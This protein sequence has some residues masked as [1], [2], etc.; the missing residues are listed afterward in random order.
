MVD[1]HGHGVPGEEGLA[2]EHPER[3]AAEGVE[4]GGLAAGAARHA[5]GGHVGRSPGE[6]AVRRDVRVVLAD[7]L[8]EAEVEDLDDVEVHA[9][10]AQEEVGR[11]DVA[12]QEAGLVRLGERAA[13]LAQHRD[14]ARRGLGPKRCTSEARSRPSSSS[15][16]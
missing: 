7:R 3:H 1:E 8:H 5:L 10:P 15:M 11:L 6:R 14:H 16:T 13:R 12:V 4:V 2:G 9:E